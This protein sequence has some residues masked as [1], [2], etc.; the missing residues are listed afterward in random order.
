MSEIP[1][2]QSFFCVKHNISYIGYCPKCDHDPWTNEKKLQEQHE[3]VKK[4][5][6]RIR[7]MEKEYLQGQVQGK[8]E[9]QQFQGSSFSSLPP[10]SSSFEIPWKY[11]WTDQQGTG[12]T[13]QQKQKETKPTFLEILM[14]KIDLLSDIDYKNRLKVWEKETSIQEQTVKLAQYIAKTLKPFTL[15]SYFGKAGIET[16]GASAYIIR[17]GGT[18]TVINETTA[19]IDSAALQMFRES[20]PDF[21]NAYAKQ[22]DSRLLDLEDLNEMLLVF[23]NTLIGKLEEPEKPQ[24]KN[25]TSELL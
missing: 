12:E 5:M 2:S 21:I 14:K 20:L 18:P 1:E 3:L 19:K 6:M 17:T 11:Q 10:S 7:Q 24:N 9:M 15:L 23:D 22:H 16:D 8:Q 25:F 13:G 4:Q